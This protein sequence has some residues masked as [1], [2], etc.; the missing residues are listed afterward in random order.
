MQIDDLDF[1]GKYFPDKLQFPDVTENI[2]D[3]FMSNQLDV[4]NF[5]RIAADVILAQPMRLALK[6]GTKVVLF[7]I[8]NHVLKSHIL[9]LRS[10]WKYQDAILPSGYAQH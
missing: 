10:L 9:K 8:F 2:F 6:K 4:H 7:Q 5:P 1:Q 3:V